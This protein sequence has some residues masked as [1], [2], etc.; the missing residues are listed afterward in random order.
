MQLLQICYRDSSL[1][2]QKYIFFLMLVVQCI[3]PD[4]FGVS[5]YSV[6]SDKVTT[7]KGTRKT[8]YLIISR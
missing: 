6:K 7:L 8:D 3:H 1:Q 4:C 2:N 5:C